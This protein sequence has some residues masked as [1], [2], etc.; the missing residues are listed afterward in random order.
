MEIVKCAVRNASDC[1]VSREMRGMDR[2]EPFL[3]FIG[4]TKDVL[5]DSMVAMVS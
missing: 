4:S 2:D 3:T 1:G 5:L